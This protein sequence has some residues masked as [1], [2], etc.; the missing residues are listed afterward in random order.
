MNRA[1]GPIAAVALG[2][3]MLPALCACGRVGTL[4]QPP[5][6]WGAKAK[7]DYQARKA[8]AAAAKAKA[9]KDSDGPEPLDPATPGPNDPSPAP[10]TLRDNPAPGMRTLPGAPAQPGVLPDPYTRPQ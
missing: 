10:G 1:A 4:D 7:A 3:A 5:P 2:A 9:G 8:E 6:L